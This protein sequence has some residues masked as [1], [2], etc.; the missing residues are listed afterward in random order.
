[1]GLLTAALPAA[2][3]GTNEPDLPIAAA[4]FLLAAFG[5]GIA[6][7]QVII[8]RQYTGR[9]QGNPYTWALRRFVPWVLTLALVLAATFLGMLALLIPGIYI[10]VRLFWADEF[11][12]THQAG[13]LQALKESWNLTKNN[14]GAVFTF[15]FLAGLAAYLVIIAGVLLLAG[16]ELAIDALGRPEYLGPLEITL[17]LL[18]IF[19]GYGALHAPEIVRL[20]GM[21]AERAR[22]V[23]TATTTLNI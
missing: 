16:M 17:I 12:L 18:V 21:R 20:Y 15:Q 1:M 23:I 10:G 19:V 14:A 11:A 6:L 2:P 22:S 13:P 9:V 4:V 3:D 8:S 5:F 7:T